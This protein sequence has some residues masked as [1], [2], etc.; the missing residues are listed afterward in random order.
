M[1]AGARIHN[2]LNTENIESYKGSL[3]VYCWMKPSRTKNG[4]LVTIS[5]KS[6]IVEAVGFLVPTHAC[7]VNGLNLFEKCCMNMLH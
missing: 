1:G 6:K 7:G 4:N 5:I 2:L 3:I